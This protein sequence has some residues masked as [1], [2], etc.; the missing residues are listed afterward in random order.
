MDVGEVLRDPAPFMPHGMCLLWDP[1]LIWL[2]LSSDVLTALAYCSIPVTLFIFV[3]RRKDL[4]FGWIFVLFGLFIAAC[5]TTH[6][7]AP[8]PCGTWITPARASS[9]R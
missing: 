9:R 4:A 5:G 7:L 6:A 1:A 3:R 2:H 8:G